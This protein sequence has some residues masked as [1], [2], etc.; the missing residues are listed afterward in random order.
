VRITSV[1]STRLLKVARFVI[2]MLV[3][4][5]DLKHRTVSAISRR[6]VIRMESYG[7]GSQIAMRQGLGVWQMGT[8]SGIAHIAQCRRNLAVPYQSSRDL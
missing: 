3:S 6:L 7:R 4:P 1:S 5:L 8:A 2:S